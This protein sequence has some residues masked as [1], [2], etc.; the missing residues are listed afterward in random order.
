[1]EKRFFIVCIYKF[2]PGII[3]ALA[4]PAL[5]ACTDDASSEGGN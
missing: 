5:H 1:M 3:C 2:F 4:V